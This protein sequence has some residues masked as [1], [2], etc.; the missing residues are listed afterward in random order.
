MLYL[1]LNIYCK[2][3]CVE[4]IILAGRG[5]DPPAKSESSGGKV[6]EK[7]NFEIKFFYT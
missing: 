5:P 3:D 7:Y 4:Y 2:I 6:N 1:L